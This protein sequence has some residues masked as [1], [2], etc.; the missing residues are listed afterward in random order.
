MLRALARRVR[1]LIQA[2]D[3]LTRTA[4][5]LSISLTTVQIRRDRWLQA[6]P[7][8]AQPE[9][10]RRPSK[11]GAR[12]NRAPALGRRNCR[13]DRPGLRGAGLLGSRG[14]TLDAG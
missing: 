7:R 8:L 6:R 9:Q 3:G 5:R 13:A 4:K 1:I 14:E 11:S 2:H 12:M 10:V